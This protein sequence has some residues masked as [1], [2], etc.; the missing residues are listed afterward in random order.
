M[1]RL[2]DHG[3]VAIALSV[4]ACATAVPGDDVY[5]LDVAVDVTDPQAIRIDITFVGEELGITALQ[6]SDDFGFTKPDPAWFSDYELSC[7]SDSCRL[8]DSSS[9]LTLGVAHEPGER[10][11]L[12]YTVTSPAPPLSDVDDYRP[13]GSSEGVAFYSGITLWMPTAVDEQ[14]KLALSH[15]WQG[16]PET[17]R[18]FGPLGSGQ[19]LQRGSVRGSAVR[20]LL[21]AAGGLS[22]VQELGDGAELG[23]IALTGGVLD[24]GQAMRSVMPV[25][26][27]TR[28]FFPPMEENWYFIMASEAGPEIENGFSIGGTAVRSAFALYLSPGLALSDIDRVLTEIIAHEYFHNWNGILFY[29]DE[30]GVPHSTRWFVEGFTDYYARVM[31]LRSGLIDAEAFAQSL[32]EYVQGYEESPD[33]N[34]DQEAVRALW[35][36]NDERSN[37]SYRRGDLIALYINETLRAET[38]GVITLDDLMIELANRA[39]DGEDQPRAA[40]VFAW[41][42]EA[43]SPALAEAVERLVRE[44]GAIPRPRQVTQAGFRFELDPETGRYGVMQG[45]D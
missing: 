28:S 7:P 38:N 3:V 33:R 2:R 4:A 37:I 39:L 14:E 40:D 11:T 45:S 18:Y 6:L 41:I 42:A 5:R 16:G 29:L 8:L 26:E 10:V 32:N 15:R 44:G 31:S 43:G 35:L 27:T 13:S 9:A 17:W 21:F 19:A 30:E 34:L 25:I 23:A 12:S 20:E 24:P 36:E 22:A 1:L